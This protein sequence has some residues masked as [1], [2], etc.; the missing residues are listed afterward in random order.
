MEGE[1]SDDLF[2]MLKG[3]SVGPMPNGE[4][5]TRHVAKIPR[6]EFTTSSTHANVCA[7]MAMAAAVNLLENSLRIAVGRTCLYEL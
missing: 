3:Q 4:Q 1:K 6:R 7:T 2:D 5:I